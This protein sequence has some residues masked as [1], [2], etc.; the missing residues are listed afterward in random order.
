MRQIRHRRVGDKKATICI[1]AERW[2][3]EEQPSSWSDEFRQRFEGRWPIPR[4]TVLGILGGLLAFAGVVS[5]A[6]TVEPEQEAVI[7]RFGRYV[8]T[9]PPGLHFKLPFGIDSAIKVR[10][11]VIL[12]E[13]FGFRTKGTEGTRSAYDENF[14]QESM[15]LTGDLN[16]ADVEW[17][18]QYQISDPQKYLFQARNVLTNIRDI[19]QS[20]MRRVVGD[21]LV[22]DV[23]TVGRVEIT[24]EAQRLTQE[25]L[26]RYNM[27]IRI[28]TIKLQD[29]NPPE[30]VKPAFNDVNRAKQEQEQAINQAEEQYNKIIP[31]SEGKAEQ[32]IQDAEG[33]ATSLINRARGDA[34]RFTAMLQTYRSA[35]G[36][37]RTRLYLE[38]MEELYG[39]FKE[40]TLIDPSIKG[41]LPI[42]GAPAL[43]ESPAPGGHP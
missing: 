4:Q 42:F 28:V 37:T 31:E 21:R 22:S 34:G 26:D 17:I 11:K 25:V 18:L 13:E 16:V 39:R 15:T 24:E 43:K 36:A 9:E 8:S 33:Y 23:L 40:L 10:T 20:I 6:Y 35:P 38:A 1:M 32:T 3:D 19:S 41:V 2:D 5:S 12:Q 29:V 30:P 14:R 27:G 7:L